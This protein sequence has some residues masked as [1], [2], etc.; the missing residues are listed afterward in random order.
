MGAIMGRVPTLPFRT[1]DARPTGERMTYREFLERY[2]NNEHLEWVDG[3]VIEMPPIGQD[4]DRLDQFL[5]RLLGE[6]LDYHPLGE[7]RHDPFNMKTGP[8]LPG[9]A[10][11]ILFVAKKNLKRL[12][13]TYLQGPADLAIEIISPGSRAIDRGDKYYEY[14]QGGVGEYWLLDPQRKR[15]EFYQRDKAGLYVPV[16]PDEDRVYRSKAITGLWLKSDWLWFPF[17][18]LATVRRE[19]KL[20]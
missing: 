20:T 18:T 14:E 12:K 15:A 3:E 17:P 8:S 10:P 9:R 16:P 4:H 6:F 7:L 19:W 13:K 2:D 11:D 1:R 5:L